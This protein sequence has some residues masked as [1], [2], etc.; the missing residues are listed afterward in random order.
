MD[1]T[2]LKQKLTNQEIKSIDEFQQNFNLIIT[3]C[4]QYN[5]KG[6]IWKSVE[7]LESKMIQ[8]KEK[9]N[10]CANSIDQ[11]VYNKMCL[12]DKQ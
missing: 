4:I 9:Q 3:N 5:K 1:L 6:P 12:I 7:K 8:L 10:L 2:T 11:N